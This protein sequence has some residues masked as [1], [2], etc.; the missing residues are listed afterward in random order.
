[1]LQFS[2]GF[3]LQQAAHDQLTTGGWVFLAVAWAAILWV[4]YYTFSKILGKK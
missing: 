2:L 3:F 1:M 4:T